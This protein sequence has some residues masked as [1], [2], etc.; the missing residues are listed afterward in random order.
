MSDP[1]SAILILFSLI[2]FIIVSCIGRHI[3]H[4]IEQYQYFSHH[5]GPNTAQ[6]IL[7]TK[8]ASKLYKLL[9]LYKVCSNGEEIF[10]TA[11]RLHAR[12]MSDEAEIELLQAMLNYYD[13]KL[14]KPFNVERKYT[15]KEFHEFWYRQ[16]NYVNRHEIYRLMLWLFL[17]NRIGLSQLQEM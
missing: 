1:T 15:E 12:R 13:G 9:K 10:D 17:M 4:R 5:L 7:S 14:F 16:A 3:F 11:L 6:I 8:Y 2:I